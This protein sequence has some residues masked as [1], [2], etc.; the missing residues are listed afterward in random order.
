MVVRIAR[1]LDSYHGL[2][3]HTFFI[4]LQ[5]CWQNLYGLDYLWYVF[6]GL[7]LEETKRAWARI[8]SEKLLPAGLKLNQNPPS[9]W[10]AQQVE[11]GEATILVG[12]GSKKALTPSTIRSS[13]YGCYT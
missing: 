9:Q 5:G 10:S 6:P 1:T 12:L 8:E 11:I 2:N 13:L 7:L 3:S 4:E